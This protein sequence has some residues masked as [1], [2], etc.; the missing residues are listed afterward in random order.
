[1]RVTSSPSGIEPRNSP[2]LG[3][4]ALGDPFRRIVGAGLERGLHPLVA[5]QL[6]DLV[7]SLHQAI[8]VEAKPVARFQD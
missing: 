3:Q 4:Q 6:A 2:L 1:M 8:R 7:A 5:E